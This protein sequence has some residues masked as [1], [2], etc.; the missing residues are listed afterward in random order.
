MLNGP[1]TRLKD[2][3]ELRKM[4]ARTSSRGRLGSRR[5]RPPERRGSLFYYRTIKNI[6]QNCYICI[7]KWECRVD[8]QENVEEEEEYEGEEETLSCAVNLLLLNLNTHF[9]VAVEI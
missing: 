6:Q 1:L 9:V 4:G 8:H 2:T 7:V 3:R 5:R